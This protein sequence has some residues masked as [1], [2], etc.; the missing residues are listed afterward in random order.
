[1]LSCAYRQECPGS[2]LNAGGVAPVT[3]WKRRLRSTTDSAVTKN[4]VILEGDRGLA[5]KEYF[6]AMPEHL[7]RIFKATRSPRSILRTGPLT[8]AQ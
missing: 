1:M 5:E 7:A 8:V 2:L 4:K 6:V 3:T